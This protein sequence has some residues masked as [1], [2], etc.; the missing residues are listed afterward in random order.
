[1]ASSG[2]TSGPELLVELDRARPEPLHRQLS[3]GLRD[4]IRTR[5][6]APQTRLPSTRVLAAD[7]GVS[8]RLVVDTYSQLVAEGFLLSRHGSGT[9]VAMVDATRGPS[10][11]V[12]DVERDMTSTSCQVHPTSAA[13]PATRGC[14]R[15]DRGWR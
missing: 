4:A 10:R 2:T 11:D 1:M 8:R 14:G 12:R 7:L 5:R 13:F 9:R 6:L 3:D 15:C